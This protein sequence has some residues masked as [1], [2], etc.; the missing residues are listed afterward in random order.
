[1]QYV[2]IAQDF[3]RAV[4]WANL[5]KPKV[6][7]EKHDDFYEWNLFIFG[8]R[9]ASFYSA[10][11]TVLCVLGEEEMKIQKDIISNVF[12]LDKIYDGLWDRIWDD[13][14][15]LIRLE[16]YPMSGP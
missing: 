5:A 16:F 11:P 3:V 1:M 13:G 10:Q 12:F 14:V 8:K 9:W 15:D 6:Y 4:D 7:R 2:E